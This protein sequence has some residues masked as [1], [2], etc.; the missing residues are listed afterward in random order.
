MNATQSLLWSCVET[1]RKK[2]AHENDTILGAA[3]ERG[4]PLSPDVFSN[5]NADG[6][7]G[8]NAACVRLYLG[9]RRRKCDHI[10]DKVH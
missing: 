3:E 1:G 2:T 10:F 7:L 5:T 8:S 4:K 9:G 6:T